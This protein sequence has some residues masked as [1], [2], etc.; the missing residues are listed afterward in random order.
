MRCIHG[1]EENE[2]PT[3]RIEK[4]S[5]PPISS[6][7]RKDDTN[8]LKA[9]NPY[10]KKHL[11]IKNEFENNLLNR[12]KLSQPIFSNLLPKI[13]GMTINS[14]TQNDTLLKTLDQ[15]SIDHLDKFKI[16]KKVELKKPEL[17]LEDKT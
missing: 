9:E 3:C 2:C 6:N 8:K 12:K 5:I 1:F 16:L 7:F 13:N 17:D 15:Y 11:A 10:F 14:R 4:I